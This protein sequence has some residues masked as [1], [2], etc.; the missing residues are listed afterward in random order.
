MTVRMVDAF[1]RILVREWRTENWLE[2][3]REFRLLLS[4]SI[5]RLSRSEAQDSRV[6]FDE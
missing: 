1:F 6:K 5:G 2:T 3:Q 4:T